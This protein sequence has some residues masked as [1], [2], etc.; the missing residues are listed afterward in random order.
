MSAL[1]SPLAE[2]LGTRSKVRLLRALL[3][4]ETAVSGRQA[5][6][7]A[8]VSQ[9]AAARALN[10]LDDLGIVERTVTPGEHRF[11]VN[12]RHF[13][14]EHGLVPLFNAEV[15]AVDRVFDELQRL[16]SALAL[17]AEAD[18]VSGVVFGS[19]AREED[20]PSS[21]LDLLL[22]VEDDVDAERLAARSSERSDRLRE[23]F[24][25]N[26]APMTVSR[27][28]LR[29]LHNEGARL[30]EAIRKEGRTVFGRHVED[31]LDGS[32]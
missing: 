32:A 31:L 29:Q 17:D 22:V 27:A 11:T 4:R 15:R 7:L 6:R 28:R 1:L 12:R 30:V 19:V 5:A 16:V 18:V 26:V 3:E 21:D 2:I 9:N 8:G 24:G 13:L 14:V 20:R 25:V 23:R 10:E